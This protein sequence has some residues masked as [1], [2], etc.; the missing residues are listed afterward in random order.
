MSWR[1]K[2][3]KYKLWMFDLNYLNWQDKLFKFLRKYT[4]QF[5]EYFNIISVKY[6]PH[7]KLIFCIFIGNL[8]TLMILCQFSLTIGLCHLIWNIHSSVRLRECGGVVR[9]AAGILTVSGVSPLQSLHS[10]MTKINVTL[11]VSRPSLLYQG[12]HSTA[13]QSMRL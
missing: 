6:F 1:W 5:K 4:I 3:E 2:L 10:T 7:Y 11:C 9:S 13:F 12:S 8:F